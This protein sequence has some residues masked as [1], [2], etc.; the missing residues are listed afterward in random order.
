MSDS[1][2]RRMISAYVERAPAPRFL[3]SLFTLRPE[4]IHN[5]EKVE[6]DIQRSSEDVAV[7]IQDVSTGP[8]LNENDKYTNK[9]FTPPVFDEAAGIT[10]WEQ[11]KRQPGVEPFE[12]PNFLANAGRQAM[13]LMLK[14]GDKIGRATELMASQVLQDGVITLV[15]SGGN[16]VYTIDFLMKSSHKITVGTAWATDGSTGAPARKSTRLN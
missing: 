1:S 8:R 2:T 5:T 11:I 4:N 6:I 10:A 7:P 16:T 9:A 12:D 13:G 14:M 3:S 15:D